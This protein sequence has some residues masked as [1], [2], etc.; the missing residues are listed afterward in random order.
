VR[1]LVD[2][3]VAQALLDLNAITAEAREWLE[4]GFDQR[5][6]AKNTKSRLIKVTLILAIFHRAELERVGKKG[7]QNPGLL[8][9]FLQPFGALASV[10]ASTS[11]SSVKLSTL[12]FLP[13]GARLL[14]G[15]EL[16]L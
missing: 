15:S 16:R 2:V 14:T 3:D 4:A 5:A 6:H 12:K 7:N 10:N 8:R 1:A 13:V 11:T 9:R